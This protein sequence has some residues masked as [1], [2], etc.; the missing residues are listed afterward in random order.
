MDPEVDG[1]FSCQFVSCSS[2]ARTRHVWVYNG[3]GVFNNCW[4]VLFTRWLGEEEKEEE[5]EEE[6][7][8]ATALSRVGEVKCS[9][10][11]DDFNNDDEEEDAEDE[12][13]Y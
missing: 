8:D 2:R 12:E 4:V 9:R 13:A 5:E 3:G 1:D 11:E 7:P 10:G 6:E